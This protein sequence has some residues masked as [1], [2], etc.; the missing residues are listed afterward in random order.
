MIFVSFSKK[1]SEHLGLL[2]GEEVFD[3]TEALQGT[4][5]D[6]QLK[7]RLTSRNSSLS[8]TELLHIYTGD[9]SAS[10]EPIQQIQRDLPG[11]ARYPLNQLKLLAP[12]PRPSSLRDGY[13]FRQ[14]VETMRKNRGAE[15]IPEFDQFPAFYYANHLHCF[16]PGEIRVQKNHLEKLDYELELAVVIGKAGKNIPANK[17]DEHIL[18]L[19]IWNDFSARAMQMQEMKLSLGPA[20]GKD[21]ANAFGPYLVTKDE[22]S[23]HIEQTSQGN[24]Y[25]LEMKASVNGEQLSA[26][27]AGTMDWTFAQ[28][29]ERASYGTTLYPG[30][31]IG[32]GTVG[33]GCLAE[34]NS[35]KITDNLWLQVGDRVSL[36]IEKLGTLENTIVLADEREYLVGEEEHA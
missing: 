14:H 20:K 33:S 34:L 10:F 8:M 9:V 29:I 30:E 11:N 25:H 32:S 19:M 6:S 12:V 36:E 23:D 5:K 27:S 26:G 35:S 13:A 24:R 31:I 7:Q 2:E 1:D 22:I 15:M 4:S 28:I 16:G 18:G 3:L 17:A 21:F